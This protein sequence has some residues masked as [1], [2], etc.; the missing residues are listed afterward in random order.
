LRNSDLQ[1]ILLHDSL[2]LYYQPRFDLR[3]GK[4]I[5]MEALV[6]WPLFETH[7]RP[8]SQFL[9]AAKDNQ[10]L[11]AMGEQI[12]RKA[13]THTVRWAEMGHPQLQLALSLSYHQLAHK[14]FPTRVTAILKE[15][16]LAPDQLSLEI[17][18]SMLMYALERSATTLAQLKEL[19]TRITIINFGS[20][21]LSLHTLRH[22]LISA[23]KISPAFIAGLGL[24]PDDDAIISATI[25]MASNLELITIA[26]GVE[27]KEQV[28]FL[29]REGCDQTQ[30]RFHSQPLSTE[31]FTQTLELY[32]LLDKTRSAASEVAGT[33]RRFHA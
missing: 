30:G 32:R 28:Q 10:L 23:L 20:S 11:L 24:N 16:G 5:G 21:H 8:P 33:I 19:G 12:L 3:N 9:D 25:A 7:T 15:T 29:R 31:N 2:D 6:R 13:C 17:T 26:T 4:I 1:E 18:E 14:D 27:T 22:S